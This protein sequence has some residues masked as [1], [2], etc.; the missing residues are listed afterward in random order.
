[1][2]QWNKLTPKEEQVI[3]RKGTELPFTGEYTHFSK[4]G[5]YICRRC[6]TILYHSQ[7]KFKSDCGWPSFDQV[8][9]G[10]VTEISDTDG[11]RVEIQC[12]KCDAHLGHVFRGEKLT[13]KDI[14]YCVNSISLKFIPA[15]KLGRAIFAG[16]CFWGVEYYMKKIPGVL[17]TTAGYIGGNEQNP[18]YDEVSHHKT[19]HLEAVEVIYDLEKVSYETIAKMFFEIHDPTQAN[20]QGPD[21]GEQY[22]SRVFY[23]NMEQKKIAQKLIAILKKKGLNVATK[24][25]KAGRFWKAEEYHQNYYAR[26]ESLPYCHGY[27]KRF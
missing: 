9:P 20:G 21:I 18:T 2:Q 23:L 4:K 11:I 15:S 26:K 5:T 25:Q 8:L 3:V 1:M 12:T 6:N 24:V 10:A 17:E 19:N 22:L 16:G 13:P 27:T 14:R 7:N